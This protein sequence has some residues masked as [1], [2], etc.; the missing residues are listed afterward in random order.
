MAIKTVDIA[1]AGVVESIRSNMA[2]VTETAN[3][4]MEMSFKKTGPKP[5][6]IS[7][8]GLYQIADTSVNWYQNASVFVLMNHSHAC[9]LYL[10]FTRTETTIKKQCFYKINYGTKIFF[11][12]YEKEG[13]YYLWNSSQSDTYNGFAYVVNGMTYM[14][15]YET[16]DSTYEEVAMTEIQ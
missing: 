7:L 10:M 1:D 8:T 12:V 15:K 6:S 13:K 4:L 5:V 9:T 3:G 14:G 11:K 16:L 2:A